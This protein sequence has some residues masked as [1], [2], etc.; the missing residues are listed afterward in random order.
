M[1]DPISSTASVQIRDVNFTKTYV[2]SVD[3]ISSTPNLT[4]G[5]RG[6][7]RL[8]ITLPAGQITDLVITDVLPAGLSYVSHTLDT[9]SYIGNLAPLTFNQFGNT[10]NFLS[11][12]QPTQLLTAH[13]SLT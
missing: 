5:E 10:L 8:A 1:R 3:G 13:F 6:L 12:A 11:Q 2:S 4:I 7:F 9:T